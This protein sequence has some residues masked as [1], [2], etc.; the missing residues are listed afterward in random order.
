MSICPICFSDF[1]PTQFR[2]SGGANRIYCY[3]CLPYGLP[4][5]ERVKKNRDLNLLR[6]HKL[7]IETG[8][9]IC[10]YNRTP[11]ALEFHH[12]HPESKSEDP[13]YSARL[14]W[15]RFI[16]EYEKCVLLCANCHREEQD[17]LIPLERI[18]EIYS[19]K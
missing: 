13:S 16:Q 7:K 17:G 9:Q 3:E 2:G 6:V 12:V 15:G 4:K 19:V 10:G 5:P 8:C 18:L 1:S 11:S 14:S